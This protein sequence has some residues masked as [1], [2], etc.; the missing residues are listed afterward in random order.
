M[1]VEH[2]PAEETLREAEARY[3]NLVEES[4]DGIF[5]QKGPKITFANSRLHEMLGY[6][7]GE[8]EGMDHWLI[9]HPDYQDLTRE[10]ARARMRGEEIPSH[11]EVKLRRKD[12]STF[13]GEINARATIVEGEP[14]IQVWVKDISKRKKA[15]EALRAS[16]EHF[17]QFFENAPLYC[18]MVSREGIILNVN[19]TALA[20]LGYQKE[21]LVGKPVAT[22]YPPEYHQKMNENF[23]TWKKTGRLDEVEMEIV[24]KK[25]DRRTVLLTA[26]A[27]KDG[28]GR[29]FHSISVQRDITLRKKAEESL[30]DSERRYRQLFE[31]VPVGLYRTSRDGEILEAN[32]AL[33]QMLGFPDLKSLKAVKALGTYVNPEDRIRWREIMDRDGIV[34]NFQK[35]L[36]R[37]DG[38]ILWVEEN[39]KTF[40]NSR[41]EQYYEGT[42][43]DITGRKRAEEE[44]AALQEQLRQSQKMEAIG[45]LAGGVAHDFNNL[46]TVIKGYSQLSLVDLKEN[47]PLKPNIEEIKRAADRAADLTRQLLAFGRR[48]MMEMRVLDLNTL[49]RNLEKMLRRLIG[50]D[51]SLITHFSKDLGKVK[52][53]PGQIE[54]VILNLVVNARDAMPNGGT[55]L[56]EIANVELDEAYAKKHTYVT[57]GR[58]VMLSVGD[59]GVGMAPEVRDRIFE[60]FFTTKEKGKGTGLGLSTVYGIVKQSGGNIWVYSEPGQGTTFKIYLPRVDEPLNGL[61]ENGLRGEV[62]GG[63]E[64]VLIIEDEEAVRKVASRILKKRGYRVLEASRGDEA[65]RLYE[66]SKEK[67]HLVLTDVV[68][69]GMSGPQLIGKLRGI[70]DDF[71][72]LYMSGYTDDMVVLNGALGKGANFIQKPFTFNLLSRKVREVLDG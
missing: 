50:E 33:V 23:E 35:Q 14:G 65:I 38:S 8:M 27:V 1:K 15:E 6:E 52:A 37:R 71:K 4:F 58:Y 67:I 42:L 13:S 72:V 32:P 9:Y 60:P 31:N 11:Y 61:K 57:P 53:D 41:G 62:P 26:D 47:D 3:R 12:G 56:I 2:Q 5:I 51:I 55:L 63:N 54:Q 49:L 21:E 45:Q 22:I 10:R 19:K 30:K 28:D 43:K 66:E 59:T 69:P 29:V 46:L 44:K 48:Q 68:L 16:E 17:R 24:T 34:Q 70:K 40:S 18:Y 25:G 64:T 39:A 20:T 7:K 36:R